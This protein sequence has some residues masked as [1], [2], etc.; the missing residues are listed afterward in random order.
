VLERPTRESTTAKRMKTLNQYD[1][2]VYLYFFGVAIVSIL[3]AQ[4]LEKRLK[5]R[6]PQTLPYRWGYYFGC[7]GFTLSQN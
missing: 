6:S 5:A 7:M 4:M 1:A 3:A 2:M